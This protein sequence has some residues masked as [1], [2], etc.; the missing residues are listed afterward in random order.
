MSDHFAIVAE[1]CTHPHDPP[2]TTRLDPFDD[3]STTGPSDSA[4]RST[5]TELRVGG[6]EIMPLS[7]RSA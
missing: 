6:P 1:C 2:Q 4:K 5:A 3:I 7:R